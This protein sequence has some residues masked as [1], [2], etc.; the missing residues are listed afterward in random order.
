[1]F[2]MFWLLKFHPLDDDEENEKEG[3]VV[4]KPL[5]LYHKS[6]DHYLHHI[7]LSIYHNILKFTNNAHKD[8]SLG[9][10]IYDI[11]EYDLE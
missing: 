10:K 8:Y 4:F 11:S 6:H 2:E 5:S 7:G 3:E 9:M 1:M